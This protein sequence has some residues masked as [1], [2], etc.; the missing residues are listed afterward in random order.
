MSH[1]RG[2]GADEDRIPRA[3]QGA[4]RLHAARTGWSR[5]CRT[6]PPLV[7]RIAW[8]ANLR[9]RIP[10]AAWL[11]EKLLGLSARR[12]LPRW[13]SRHVSGGRARRSA[14]FAEPRHELLE[15]ACIRRQRQWCCSSI[16]STAISRARMRSPRRACCTQAG[17]ARAHARQGTAATIA[18][19][20][21][22]WPRHGRG[23]P[24]PKRAELIDALE[25]F[26]RRG[27][28]I[29]GLEPSCLLTL[30]DEALAMGLGERRASSP[31]RRFCSRSSSPAKPGPGASPRRCEPAGQPILL[32]GHCHQKASA[33]SARSWKCCA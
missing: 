26:A 19:A 24:R 8:L 12:S 11:S 6:M 20:A 16:P 9:D 15:A 33:R 5:I 31:P 3:L 10:G 32:H 27:I 17:Y 29:V 22:I 30:R 7:S 2:H 14:L 23:A 25:P 18:A 21:P 28:A 1:R 4:A 13:R